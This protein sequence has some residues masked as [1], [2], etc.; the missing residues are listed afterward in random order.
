MKRFTCP[1]F[2]W[3]RLLIVLAIMLIAVG[4]ISTP[5]GRSITVQSAAVAYED[6]FATTVSVNAS[7]TVAAITTEAL[8]TG[9]VGVTVV[10][11]SATV[12]LRYQCDATAADANSFGIPPG[13][14]LFIPGNAT[15]LADVRLYTGS[16]T[17]VG[18]LYHALE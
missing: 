6:T 9:I 8:P 11:Y 12:T 10:N 1:D 4:F 16:A 7:T 14:G 13:N 2:T 3:I 18:F 17:D 5:S 15:K